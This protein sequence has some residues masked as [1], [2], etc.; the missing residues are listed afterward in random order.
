[1]QKSTEEFRVETE[2]VFRKQSKKTKRDM[3][4]DKE[5]K[6]TGPEHPASA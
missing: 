3:S 5:V 2:E 1:M 6:R 4:L